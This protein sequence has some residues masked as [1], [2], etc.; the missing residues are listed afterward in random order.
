MTGTNPIIHPS[1]C[2][3]VSSHMP[4][5]ILVFPSVFV[6]SLAYSVHLESPEVTSV[7]IL[8][9]YGHSMVSWGVMKGSLHGSRCPCVVQPGCAVMSTSIATAPHDQMTTQPRNSCS[10]QALKR[11]ESGSW[12]LIT[13]GCVVTEPWHVP[14]LVPFQAEPRP[15]VRNLRKIPLL[16]LGL[17]L[18]VSVFGGMPGS[19]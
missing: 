16:S 9:G 4:S 11:A 5:S 13:L 14:L 6:P 2:S 15:G 3:F 1:F 8:T 18:A 19:P 17:E 10:Y 12:G 7:L